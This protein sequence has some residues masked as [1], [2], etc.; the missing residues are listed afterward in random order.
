MAAAKKS[1]AKKSTTE[2]ETVL[3]VRCTPEEKAFWVAMAQRSGGTLSDY[4]KVRLPPPPPSWR[5]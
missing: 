5:R 3:H 4:V 1:A 2:K